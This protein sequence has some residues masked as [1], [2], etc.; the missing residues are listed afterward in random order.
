MEFLLSLEKRYLYSSII[1]WNRFFIIEG[2]FN[3][4]LF[5]CAHYGKLLKKCITFIGSLFFFWFSMCNFFLT[6]FIIDIRFAWNHCKKA[7]A[8]N[9][10]KTLDDATRRRSTTIH[11]NC[12]CV[13]V[14]I[15]L[16]VILLLVSDKPKVKHTHKR[17][18]GMY[19]NFV[20]SRFV[21]RIH[22]TVLSIVISKVARSPLTKTN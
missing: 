4:Y 16:D 21:N 20:E 11:I 2:S 3:R 17:S 19:S 14:W 5:V 22:I 18:N 13:C 12:M 8:Q 7:F 10:Q 1:Q 9:T 6:L 15:S